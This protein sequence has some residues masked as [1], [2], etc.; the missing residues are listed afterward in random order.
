MMKHIHRQ[1]HAGCEF[2]NVV[3]HNGQSTFELD[4]FVARC[5]IVPVHHLGSFQQLRV[6]PVK[7]VQLK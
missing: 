1:E 6:L 7:I 5:E 4:E 2:S 3:R